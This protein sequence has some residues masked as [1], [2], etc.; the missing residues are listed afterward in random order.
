MRKAFYWKSAQGR[1]RQRSE[2]AR[3]KPKESA[4]K[5][6][7]QQGAVGNLLSSARGFLFLKQLHYIYGLER[8]TAPIKCE[9][10]F[11]GKARKDAR[12]SG[13]KRP[14]GSRRSRRPE[15]KPS[16]G[17]RK[18]LLLNQKVFFILNVTRPFSAAPF[19]AWLGPAPRW[20]LQLR[21]RFWGRLFLARRR[22]LPPLF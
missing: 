19:L 4:T 3:R 11:I 17:R 6:Q 16:R 20:R 13:R 18:G 7:A 12:D 10:H 8:E 9:K 15:G 1:A 14:V 21:R 22:W 2:A 5:G